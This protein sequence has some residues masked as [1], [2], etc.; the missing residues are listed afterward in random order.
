M[1]KNTDY[2]D[3]YSKKNTVTL[4]LLALLRDGIPNTYKK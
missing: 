4:S 1:I 3:T 2:S